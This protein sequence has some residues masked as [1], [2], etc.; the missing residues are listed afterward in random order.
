MRG[1]EILDIAEIQLFDTESR[2]RKS[3]GHQL[4]APAVH[5]CNRGACNQFTGQFERVGVVHVRQ[6]YQSHA[7]LWQAIGALQ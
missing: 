7:G 5:G 1:P 4:L 2:G 6:F 3:R